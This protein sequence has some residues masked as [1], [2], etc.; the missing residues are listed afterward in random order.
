[1]VEIALAIGILGIALV[2]IVGVLPVGLNVQKDN[3]EDTLVE[4]EGDF[5]MEV[6]V[7]SQDFG[8]ESLRQGRLANEV[9]SPHAAWLD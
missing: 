5:F 2:A 9:P 4:Q 1:M 3:R 6:L 8:R 7:N